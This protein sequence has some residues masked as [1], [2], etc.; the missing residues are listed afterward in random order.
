MDF[1]LSKSCESLL[2]AAPSI[3][4]KPWPSDGIMV[5][6]R[7]PSGQEWE[8]GEIACIN[9]DGTYFILFDEDRFDSAVKEEYVYEI[10]NNCPFVGRRF[11]VG[12]EVEALK[13]SPIDFDPTDKWYR[14]HIT[15]LCNKGTYAIQ[16]DDGEE[17]LNH[18][19]SYIRCI[20]ESFCCDSHRI[21]RYLNKWDGIYVC[22]DC[23]YNLSLEKDV[24]R[25]AAEEGR[26]RDTPCDAIPADK[27][28]G[29]MSQERG[30][31]IGFLLE[32]TKTYNCWEWN[33]W[34]VIRK[35]IKPETELTRCRY[36]ELPKMAKHVG[37]AQSFISYAQAG[38]W[39]DLVAGVADGADPDRKVWIDVFA[40]R[41]WPSSSPD[42][43]FGST[44][45]YCS[46]FIIICSHQREVDS[47]SAVDLV[48]RN[49]MTLPAVTRK[50]IS[51]L[52]VWCLVEAHT[53]AIMAG[54]PFLMKVGRHEL[55]GDGTVHFKSSPWKM[56]NNLSVLVD[57]EQAEAT[58][59][60]D[61]EHILLSIRRSCGV[62]HLNHVIRGII[63][64]AEI[65]IYV[66]NANM[67]Q[68]AACGDEGA[69][70]AV[71]SDPTNIDGAAAGGYTAL[72]EKLLDSGADIEYKDM[73]RMGA[74][75]RTA[76]GAAAYAGHLSVVLLLL[77][78]GASFH[79]RNR[80]NGDTVLIEAAHGGTKSIR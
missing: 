55:L 78:R 27:D 33:S 62:D 15:R 71:L 51:F 54:M 1:S 11:H 7:Y 79:A 76:L 39:G 30:V 49:M 24:A 63:Q 35:I 77:S 17:V 3:A 5:E 16:Y 50:Q 68:C 21:H 12:D 25:I 19:E 44:I 59:A 8:L 32:F 23:F 58:V 14:G 64:G 38:K 52:R 47:M 29:R 43:D 37:P 2:N 36:V 72:V 9:K 13:V 60:S 57:I 28:V 80:V 41:Q 65:F 70:A 20:D 6:V 75:G 46:S 22:M 45:R 69:L 74:A 34:E 53:A 73:A 18:A 67:I 31:S 56:L 4:S 10:A 48:S 26:E 40:V 42:L 66:K 61:K